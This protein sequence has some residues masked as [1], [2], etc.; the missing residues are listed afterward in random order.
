MKMTGYTCKYTPIELISAFSEKCVFLGEEA[1]NFEYSQALT[2]SNFCTHA[3][4]LIE[5]VHRKNIR[6]LVLVNCCDSVRRVYDVLKGSLDFVFLLDLPHDDN[7]CA[8]QR[9]AAQLERLA[10]EYSS[11]CGK[12]F[13][14]TA[15]FDAFED[16]KGLSDEKYIAVAGA[17]A[18]E[19][20][21]KTAQARMPF[22]TVDMTCSGNRH[23]GQI[24]DEGDF[25][26][27]ML[28]YAR[29]ILSQM[30]CM[31]MTG[32]SARENMFN[33]ENCAGIIYHTVKFCDY[34]DF[35]FQRV[36]KASRIP[37]LKIETDFTT[38][39]AGQLSTRF[40]GFSEGFSSSGQK[41]ET[42]ARNPSGSLYA[43]IDSGSTTT[44]FVAFDKNGKIAASSVVRTGANAAAGAQKAIEAAGI[45]SSELA[46]TV[47]TGYGRKNITLANESITEITC[48]AK[49]ARFL[50]ADADT[51]IDIGGQDSKIIR[52][53]PDGSVK[54]FSMND[55]CA[56]GT[57]RFLEN[58]A[59]VLEISIDEMAIRGIK[60]DNDL[61][62]SSMCTVFA[63][64]EVVSLIAENVS[65][66][67]IIHALNKSV[68]AKT[69]SLLGKLEQENTL[70]MTGGVANNL[71]VVSEIEK[72]VGKPV[73]IPEHPE[74]C[75][76]LG[77]ALFALEKGQA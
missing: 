30:P 46:Y 48:H 21:L 69:K 17:R 10:G 55:K 29:S 38:Q 23:V 44:N 72:L 42:A 71:G 2:H 33:D 34:Y 62:I 19:Q 60:Y 53:N 26:A 4:A 31:R 67:D 14:R 8:V 28:M 74:L 59:K 37:V 40:E 52:L 15:F 13:S 9:L 18:G 77:A 36:A 51:I 47:A 58:M 27:L 61:T 12:T 76:A 16:E 32:I 49:G 11:F 73:L 3:K 57:G 39:A 54:G 5:E 65:I 66:P 43:G 50:N 64:S 1:E 56:A 6:S 68:A 70:I 75:G 7:E 22:K 25:S 24:P 20:F 63:E 45:D 41:K 35:D